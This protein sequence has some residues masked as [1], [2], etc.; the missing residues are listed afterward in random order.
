MHV[1]AAVDADRLAGHEVAVVGG[2]EN[3]RA[4]QIRRVL[5]ALK[6]AALAGSDEE[7]QSLRGS[8]SK[9]SV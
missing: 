8:D 6:G 5:L 9:F 2:D 7:I 4:D 3:H 1:H